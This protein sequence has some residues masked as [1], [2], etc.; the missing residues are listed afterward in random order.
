MA[1][2]AIRAAAERGLQVPDDLSVVGFDD[3]QLAPHVNPPLTTLRQDKLGLGAAAGDALVAR[4]AGDPGSPPLRTLPVELIVR[5]SHRRSR[6]S[7]P[8]PRPVAFFLA[9]PKP[10]LSPIIGGGRTPCPRGLRSSLGDRARIRPHGP[11]GL[12]RVRQQ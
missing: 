1:I 10:F 7:P 12:W 8:P 5:G 4:I 9:L 11:C 3:I 6:R 2:G